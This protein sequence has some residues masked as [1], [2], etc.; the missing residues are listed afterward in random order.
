MGFNSR[1]ILSKQYVEKWV[2]LSM[3]IG[4]DSAPRPELDLV[5]QRDSTYSISSKM[6]FYKNKEKERL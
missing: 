4:D 1:D 2:P 6:C 5:Q 3:R